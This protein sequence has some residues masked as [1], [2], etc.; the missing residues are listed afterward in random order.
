MIDQVRHFL[1]LHGE[2]RF[3]DIER[4]VVNDN[5]TPRTMNKAGFR[6][7]NNDNNLEYYCYPEVFKAEICKGFDYR[8]V[9]RLL[10]DRGYMQ[11]GDGRNLAVKMRLPG[12]GSRRVFHV[13]PSIWGSQDD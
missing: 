2:A 10:I 11:R 5:H 3:T 4:T 13:L 8:V 9:A 12:E 7:K 6:K 1:E